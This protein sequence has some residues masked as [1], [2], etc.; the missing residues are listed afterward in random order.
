MKWA[1]PTETL[2]CLHSAVCNWEGRGILLS[3][4]VN[5]FNLY[6]DSMKSTLAFSVRD[7]SGSSCVRLHL[8][9]HSNSMPTQGNSVDGSVD[10]SVKPPVIIVPP[11]LP[12]MDVVPSSSN[13]AL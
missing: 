10:G 6:H 4:R 13:M 7:R 5:F 12:S 8:F 1:G 3:S 11:S 2:E 9:V